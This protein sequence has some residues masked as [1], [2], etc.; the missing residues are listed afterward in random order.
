MPSVLEVYP[1]HFRKVKTPFRDA[2]PST[3]VLS[4]EMMRNSSLI[5]LK[6]LANWT[7]NHVLDNASTASFAGRYIGRRLIQ[8]R[9]E[10]C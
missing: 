1:S 3:Q 5:P 4:I 6:C 2:P 10:I 9:H 7:D 8:A